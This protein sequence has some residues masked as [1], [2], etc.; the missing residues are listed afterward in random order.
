MNISSNTAQQQDL[1]YRFSSKSTNHNPNQQ[2]DFG[3]HFESVKDELDRKLEGVECEEERN[4]IV[5]DVLGAV[6]LGR[7]DPSKVDDVLTPETRYQLTQEDK[8]YFAEKYDLNNMNPAEM[9][10][11]LYEMEL[12]GAITQSERLS[13]NPFI[14]TD[15]SL[16]ASSVTMIEGTSCNFAENSLGFDNFY[17]GSPLDY[18]EERMREIEMELIIGGA[19]V[20]KEAHREELAGTQLIS[21]LLSSIFGE[22]SSNSTGVSHYARTTTEPTLSEELLEQM[23]LERLFYDNLIQN[24]EEN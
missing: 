7:F 15:G 1:S 24:M 21:G 3:N 22:N 14:N 9:D 8:A 4:E 19:N 10:E 17:G 6:C 20:E 16:R 13:V 12:M 11:M 2:S 5:K 18:W 23:A